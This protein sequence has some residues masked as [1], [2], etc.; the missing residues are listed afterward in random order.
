MLRFQD[1]ERRCDTVQGG[2]RKVTLHNTVG[3]QLNIGLAQ[4]LQM[5]P[6]IKAKIEQLMLVKKN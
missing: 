3:A 2:L 1:L 5:I 6:F 4:P